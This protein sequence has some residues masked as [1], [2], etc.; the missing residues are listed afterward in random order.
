MK[1]A[2]RSNKTRTN[3]TNYMSDD[4]FADINRTEKRPPL[5]GG[6]RRTP[7]KPKQNPGPPEPQKENGR[8]PKPSAE[9]KEGKG[10]PP[11]PTPP[12]HPPFPPPSPPPQPPTPLPPPRGAHPTSFYDLFFI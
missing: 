8:R 3:K 2:T 1:A 10:G 12:Q 6:G 5:F 11:P 4:A 9:G 7:L